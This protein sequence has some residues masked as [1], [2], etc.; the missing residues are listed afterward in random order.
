MPLRENKLTGALRRLLQRILLSQDP[1]PARY[2]LIRALDRRFGIVKN[3]QHK[4]DYGAIDRA[5]YG[6]CM[7]QSAILARK[8]GHSRISCIEFG[9]GGGAGL[10]AMERHAEAV[11]AETGVEVVVFGLIPERACQHRRTTATCLISGNPAI[12]LWTSQN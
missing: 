10:V 1:I 3:Y 6:Y 9:V 5:H 11:H 7:L 12:L 2:L 8:L 4:L